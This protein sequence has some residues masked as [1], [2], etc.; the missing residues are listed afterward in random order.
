MRSGVLIGVTAWVLGAVAA[1]GGSMLA[2]SHLAHGVLGPDA[3]QLSSAAVSNDLH[4][5]RHVGPA[6]S[7]APRARSASPRP[8]GR[9]V[10]AAPDPASAGSD[11]A[12]QAG[13]LLVSAAGSV[14]ASCQVAGAYLLYWSPDQGY[15]ADD[16]SRGPTAI[17]SVS[18]ESAD[19]GIVMRVSCDGSVPV[20][21]T[22]QASRDDTDKGSGKDE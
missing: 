11:A 3:Q 2:V 20:A 12:G 16:V 9:R 8:T 14:M 10:S 18:F 19:A 22:F 7:P 13:T 5:L 1:T 4:G 15:S 17:A 6:P 21:H